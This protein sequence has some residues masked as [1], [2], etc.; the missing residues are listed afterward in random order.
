MNDCALTVAER[1]ACLGVSVRTF[2]R[3]NK[4]GMGPKGSTLSAL[5]AWL[6]SKEKAAHNEAAKEILEDG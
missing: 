2:Q 4:D 3:L 5:R 1:A 6:K